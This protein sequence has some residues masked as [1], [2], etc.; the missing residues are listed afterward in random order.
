MDAVT[1]S[2]S[3]L[4]V[5]DIWCRIDGLC[6]EVRGELEGDEARVLA[7]APPLASRVHTF[8]SDTDQE[9]AAARRRLEDMLARLHEHGVEARGLIG[10][11]DPAL[12]IDDA[13]A[14]FAADKLIVVTDSNGHQ[15]WRERRL[16]AYLEGLGLPVTHILVPH[17]LA[18]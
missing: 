13:L 1:K 2:N 10:A 8:S 3:L 6:D 12:A 5:A 14:Q 4:V 17:E 15:N 18:E 16:P 11:H 7:V 9:T